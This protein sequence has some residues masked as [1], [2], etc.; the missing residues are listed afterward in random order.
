MTDYLKP[1]LGALSRRLGTALAAWLLAGGLPADFVEA[2]V[3]H[4][5]ALLALGSDLV[6]SIWRDRAREATERLMMSRE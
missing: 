5:V 1:L 2:A 6:L 4:I 3:V